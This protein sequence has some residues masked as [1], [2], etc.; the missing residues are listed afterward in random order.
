MKWLCAFY[1]QF[2]FRYATRLLLLD[3]CANSTTTAT[4]AGELWREL[5]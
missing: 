4:A 1:R 3:G 2:R 5:S